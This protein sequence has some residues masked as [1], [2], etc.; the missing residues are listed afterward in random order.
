MDQ[1]SQEDF[2]SANII[3]KPELMPCD[4]ILDFHDSPSW[5]YRIM[6][7]KVLVMWNKI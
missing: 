1:W 5:S 2:I 7:N 6:K 4:Y 3:F